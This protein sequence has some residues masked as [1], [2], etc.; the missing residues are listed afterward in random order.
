VRNRWIND[1]EPRES[2]NS[3]GPVI[4]MIQTGKQRHRREEEWRELIAAWKASG[5][6]RRRWCEEHGVGHESMRRWCKRLR[7][8]SADTRFVEVQGAVNR[9]V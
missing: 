6:T 5:K 8:T 1:P 9:Q 4:D 3:G 2:W 7:G